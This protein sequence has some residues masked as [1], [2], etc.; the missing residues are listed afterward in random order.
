MSHLVQD[1]AQLK[2]NIVVRFAPSPTGEMHLGNMRT[3]MVNYLFAKSQGGKFLLRIEDTDLQRSQ[4]VFEDS[5]LEKLSLMGIQWD[6]DIVYQSK[7]IQYHQQVAYE[8]MD[9]GFAY[10]CQCPSKGDNFQQKV[11]CQCESHQYK[12]GALRFK[13]PKMSL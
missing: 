7:N 9:K 4:K 13:V 12:D 1:F 2:K 3:A 8:L 11:L 10:Y 6:G 5:L